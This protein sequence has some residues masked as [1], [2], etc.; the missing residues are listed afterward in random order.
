MS[1]K[2]GNNIG[3]MRK[4]VRNYNDIEIEQCMKSQISTG[5]NACL[6]AS[7]GGETMNLLAKAGFM[8]SLINEG[9]SMSDALRE[10]GKRMRVFQ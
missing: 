3:L 5:C 4:L 8:H 2:T 10:L 7:D 9:Y 1:I 6:Q